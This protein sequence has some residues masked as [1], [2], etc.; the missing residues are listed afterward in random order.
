MPEYDYL[1]EKC[2]KKFSIFFSISELNTMPTVK[3]PHCQSDKVRKLMT[4][5]FAKTSKKS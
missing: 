1:C 3:C 2:G 5:F 4:G